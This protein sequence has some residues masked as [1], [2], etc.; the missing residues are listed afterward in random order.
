MSSA[1]IYQ[2]DKQVKK[3]GADKANWYVGCIAPDSNK[4]G[5]SCG[6]GLEGYRHAVKLRKKREAELIAHFDGE[7]F[8]LPE[9]DLHDVEVQLL[10]RALRVFRK[11]SPPLNRL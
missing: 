2:D 6:P 3:H 10:P 4:R 1:W 5:K 7:F 8:C 11:L 9:D